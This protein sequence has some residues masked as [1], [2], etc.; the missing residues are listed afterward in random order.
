M[1]TSSIRDDKAAIL[2]IKNTMYLIK[3]FQTAK[4][5][6]SSSKF[7]H[8]KDQNFNQ[9]IFNDIVPKIHVKV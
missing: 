5:T 1:N 9:T 3:M 6:D 4:K 2:S 7:L 8:V